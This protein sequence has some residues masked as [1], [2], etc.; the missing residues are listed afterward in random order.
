M[1]KR[2]NEQHRM[3]R[4]VW[5][6]TYVLTK[7][8]I[9]DVVDSLPDHRVEAILQLNDRELTDYTAVW[10]NNAF[11]D[12]KDEMAAAARPKAELEI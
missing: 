6:V 12:Y 3:R 9:A 1:K 7:R 5:K 4:R 2:T 8:Q 10:D 11:H